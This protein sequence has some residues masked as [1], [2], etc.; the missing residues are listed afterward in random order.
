VGLPDLDPHL[1]PESL[2]AGTLSAGVRKPVS[3][4][5]STAMS[6]MTEGDGWS[7]TRA[8][9]G[10]MSWDGLSGGWEDR[11]RAIDMQRLQSLDSISWRAT[12]TFWQVRLSGQEDWA[13]P[14][15]QLGMGPWLEPSLLLD[16][17]SLRPLSAHGSTQSASHPSSALDDWDN[18]EDQAWDSLVEEQDH[19][20]HRLI[21]ELF[22]NWDT[23]E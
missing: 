1:F 5:S 12:K 2:M 13:K 21:D 17:W 15:L 3:S 20:A 9:F 7:V 10:R 22:A 14:T 11:A 8:G 16:D 18:D 23:T 4:E 6:F 19:E